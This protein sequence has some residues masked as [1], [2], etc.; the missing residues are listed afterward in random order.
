MNLPFRQDYYD[1][2]PLRTALN[3][4]A[5]IS[6]PGL[7]FSPWNALPYRFTDYTP[8]SY[9]DG[10]RVVA[11]VS[12]SPIEL[13]MDDAPVAAVQL[14]TVATR[15]EYRGRGLARSL[16][17]K[18]HAFWEEK[19]SLFFLFAAEEAVGF[20]EKLGYR[21]VPEYAF[22]APLPSYR[23]A[24]EGARALDLAIE[25]D[26]DL[27]FDLAERRAPVSHR[28]GVTH[29]TWLLMFHAVAPYPKQ[30]TYIGP[31]GVAAIMAV[32]GNVLR[33]LDVVGPQI[34]SFAEI[35]PFVNQPEME[36]VDFGFTPDRLAPR[37]VWSERAASSWL[38]VRGPLEPGGPFRFPATSHA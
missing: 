5:K 19:R 6:F 15:A 12:A 26:R 14:G 29:H 13:V 33:L 28:L 34:P 23:V 20:Y 11:N 4:F 31:L 35:A 2:P 22:A 8:F 24:P 21:P 16:V 37:G 9:F 27:L 18:A 38:L 30:I 36:S 32:A 17:E 1:N 25:A 3:E 7:D 10:D